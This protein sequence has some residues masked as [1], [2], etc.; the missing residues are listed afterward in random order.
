[1]K[2]GKPLITFV[3]VAIAAALSVYFGFYVFDTF[4]D[5]FTTTL[6]YQYT[7]HDSVEA[8]GLLVRQEQVLAGPGGIVDV[9]RGE[10]EK[11]G[12]GQQV[13]LIHRDSQAQ[14][15]QAELERLALEIELLEYAITDSGSIESAARLDEDILQAVVDLRAS[16]AL[17][18]YNELEDQIKAV[19]SGVLKRGYTYGDGLTSAD[20]SDRLKELKS[21]HAALDRQTASGTTQVKADRAGIYSTL[22]DGYEDILTPE[23]V[24]QLTP[25]VL[26]QMT[27]GGAVS[28]VVGKLITSDRWYFVCVLP[29]QQADRLREGRTAKLRFTGDFSQDVDM[30]VEQIGDPEGDKTA[31]VFSTDRYL[32][33]TTLLR[34]QTAELIFESWSGLRVPKEAVH[35]VKTTHEDP[36]TG[37]TTESSRLGVYVL[38][39]GRAEFKAVEVVTEGADYYILRG[40]STGS[41]ALRAGDEII[42]NALGL[43]D[44]QLLEY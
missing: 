23:T 17:G 2:Q 24:F 38:V 30:L 11:V 7:V 15:D 6:A 4:N 13:A 9:T 42:L 27:G 22:V 34:R 3:M 8:D 29:T 1:M 12:V 41:R 20:L 10:G 14:A 19:K 18:D 25:A 16:A 40:L 33:Q 36:Q 5:P 26:E 28:G 35:M 31:V 43:Y 32:S 39:G 21:Q 44:G 37:E